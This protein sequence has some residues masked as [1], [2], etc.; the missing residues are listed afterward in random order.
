MCAGAFAIGLH[1]G[2][3]SM[4]VLCGG[5]LRFIAPFIQLAHFSELPQPTTDAN[6]TCNSE[7]SR[8]MLEAFLFGSVS[9]LKCHFERG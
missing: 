9:F 6:F 7:S 8:Q 1:A 2:L 5:A 4:L 3:L